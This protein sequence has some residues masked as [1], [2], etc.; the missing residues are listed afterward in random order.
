[1][2]YLCIRL[3]LLFLYLY[4]FI[5]NRSKMIN[6]LKK[7]WLAT[8]KIIYI[9]I[10][11]FTEIKNYFQMK[12]VSKNTTEPNINIRVQYSYRKNK[13]NK[14]NNWFHKS[15]CEYI[16]FWKNKNKKH[17]LGDSLLTLVYLSFTNLSEYG[18]RGR[19]FIMSDSAFS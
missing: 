3:N 11:I 15:T 13:V 5:I 9:K 18:S 17:I 4:L 16:F 19:R 10:Y 8:Y 14:F 2:N 1:M 6:L 12:I 7:Y